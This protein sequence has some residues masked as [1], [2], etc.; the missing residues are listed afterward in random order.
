[1][2]QDGDA[3]QAA[4]VRAFSTVAGVLV[5]L[6]GVLVLIGWALHIDVL[7]SVLP[8]LG[9]MKP[10]TATALLLLGY[11]LRHQATS[12]ARRGDA[13]AMLVVLVASATLAEYLTG[14]DP[15]LD[16][17]LFPGSMLGEASPYPGRMALPTASALLLLALASALMRRGPR[18]RPIAEALALSAACISV[19]ALT[20]YVYGVERLYAVGG[21]SPMAVHTALTLLLLSCGLLAS[22]PSKGIVAT[23]MSPGP[24]GRAA[25]R[26]LPVAVALPFIVGWLGVLGQ[27]ADLFDNAFGVSIRALAVI[28]VFSAVLLWNARSLDRLDGERRAAEETTRE[29]GRVLQ[30]ILDSMTDGVAVADARGQF[31]VFNRAA[32]QILGVDAG[33]TGPAGWSD[34]YG[35]FVEDGMTPF[36]PME[37]PLARAIRGEEVRDVVMMTRNPGRPEGAWLKVSARP[38]QD[39]KGVL[40]GGVALFSD[41]TEGRRLEEARRHAEEMEAI[42]RRAQEASRLKSEFLANMSHELRTPLNAIIGFAEILHDGKVGPVGAEQKEF[43]GDI[44]GSARHLLQLINDV[45]D[46]SK[47]EAGKMEFFPEAIEL[48]SL[49][50]EIRD[51]LRGL[52]AHKRIRMDVDVDDAVIGPLVIDRAK[53]KQ[54]LYNYLSNALK[55]TP[56]DGQVTVRA[57]PEGPDDFRLEVED[58][59]IGIEPV[60]LQRLFVD[61]EQLDSTAGKRYAG[62]GLGLA[63]TRRL[64]EAQGGRAGAR[65]TP[66]HGSVFHATL[67]RVARSGGRA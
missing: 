56:E 21:R 35:L 38:L 25:R 40:Q 11:A 52:A 6:T 23:I 54:I 62:T 26:L 9:A 48:T 14:T 12:S 46:L 3:R 49:V 24:G 2:N 20:G 5:L 66:G 39:P 8:G 19:V 28:A 34:L 18:A 67:P 1:L 22:Q 63:L 64:V 44:L 41:I 51:G 57:A 31:L 43:L 36:P 61:F 50:A 37:L 16:R 30:L 59:G 7:K 13:C 27:R 55:F 10:N 53:L 45:L 42:S 15:G 58:T 4:R 29:N 65:S 60:N 33:T 47:V 32:E 17:V